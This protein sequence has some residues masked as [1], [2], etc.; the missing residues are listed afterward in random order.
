MTNRLR[1]SKL[2]KLWAVLK[3]ND[4]VV[5]RRRSLGQFL[6]TL[7]PTIC[8]AGRGPLSCTDCQGQWDSDGKPITG[9]T[10]NCRASRIDIVMNSLEPP[11]MK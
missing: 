11:E 9:H 7:Y 3:W 4:A 1:N 2:E 8:G 5:F 6:A 10:E